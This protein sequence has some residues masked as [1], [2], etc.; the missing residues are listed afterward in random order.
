MGSCV[1]VD[2]VSDARS[3]NVLSIKEWIMTLDWETLLEAWNPDDRWEM[4]ELKLFDCLSILSDLPIGSNNNSSSSEFNRGRSNL[5]DQTPVVRVIDKGTKE[6]EGLRERGG[7]VA[8]DRLG[9]VGE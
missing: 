2:P 8:V 1:F 3:I 4:S 6:D 9:E 7:G 5:L